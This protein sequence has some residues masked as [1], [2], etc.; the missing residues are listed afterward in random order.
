[1]TSVGKPRNFKIAFP[2]EDLDRLQARLDDVQ[3][4]DDDIVPDAKWDYGTDLSKLK[5]LVKG[6]KQGNPC[7]SNGKPVSSP[8]GV[9]AWWRNVEARLNK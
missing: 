1:M 5:E 4:P 8:K 2:E 6:W 3:L 7:G 9:K